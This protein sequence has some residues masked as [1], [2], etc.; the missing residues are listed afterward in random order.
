MLRA[1]AMESKLE[2][3]YLV[4]GAG[5]A[6]MAFTDALLTHSDATSAAHP[7]VQSWSKA[8]RLNP[9]SALP[10]CKADPRV[11]AAREQI[12]RFGLQAATNLR[13]LL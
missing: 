6:G 8:S 2:T 11:V 7:K 12:K 5:A 9:T 10:S 4:V 3:D 1:M 13:K